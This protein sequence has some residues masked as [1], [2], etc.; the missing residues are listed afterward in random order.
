MQQRTETVT[1]WRGDKTETA[2]FW[3]GDKTEISHGVWYARQ[4]FI[5]L[6]FN[7]GTQEEETFKRLKKNQ[8]WNINGSKSSKRNEII[9]Y[10]IA[11]YI[12]SIKILWFEFPKQTKWNKYSLNF[13]TSY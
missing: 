9:M 3:R 12:T 5:W 7:D 6:N 4:S 8:I 1:F 11:Y 13:K 2:T 10:N